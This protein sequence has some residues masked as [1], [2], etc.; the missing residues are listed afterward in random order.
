MFK[1][2]TWDCLF[3]TSLFQHW[4]WSRAYP[5]H[6]L[7]R[8]LGWKV[9]VR[10]KKRS[11]DHGINSRDRIPGR[12]PLVTK[13]RDEMYYFLLK[14]VI[15]ILRSIF[16]YYVSNRHFLCQILQCTTTNAVL[17]YWPQNLDNFLKII[18]G[19]PKKSLWYDLEEKCLRNSK[20]FFD[21]VFLSIYSHLLKKL[22]L[23]KLCRKKDIGL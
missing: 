23:S 17:K 19:G 16:S 3:L 15:A 12:I 22:E 6:A 5:T 21:G 9:L 10:I 8:S 13:Y 18:Q 4:E 11:H 20:I 7:D 1:P 2:R 14:K